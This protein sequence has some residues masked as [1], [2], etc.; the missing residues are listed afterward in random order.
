MENNEKDMIQEKETEVI[1]DAA[2]TVEEVT[3]AAEETVEEVAET[4][5]AAAETVEEVA[6]AMKASTAAKREKKQARREAKAERKAANKVEEK[7]SRPNNLLLAVMILGILL[8]MFLGV[9]GYQY[10]S[11]SPSIEKYIEKDGGAEKY[12]SM[13]ID[14]Y[15]TA[16]IT[17]EGN[18]LKIVLESK[19]S[20]EEVEALK[21]YYSGD[22]WKKQ[23]EYIGAYFLTTLKA[24]ARGFSGDVTISSQ[25]NGEEVNSA[26][27]TL[28]EA[29]KALE[30]EEEDADA[31]E[32]DD[33]EEAEDAGTEEAEDE[34]DGE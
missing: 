20:D 25:L 23:L 29:K 6:P 17:A 12:G 33:S 28:K 4:A 27:L 18:S 34:G 19:A 2:E 24:N 21:E 9:K 32:S 31:E 13:M 11:L 22:E 26:T 30:P 15:T 16:A 14:Q 5:V 7:K 10:F 1:E 3:E 8:I